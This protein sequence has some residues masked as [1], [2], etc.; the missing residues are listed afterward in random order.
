MKALK[1]FFTKY[2]AYIQG[3]LLPLGPFGV[4]LIAAID[5]SFFGVPMDPIVA[6]FVHADPRRAVIYVLL[7]AV[8][9]AVGSLVPYVIGYKGGEAFVV[10]K[11]GQERFN[12]VHRLSEK[13]GELA[14]IIP[15]MMPPGFPFKLFVFSAGVAEM[16]W[17]HFMLAVFT[18]RLL[19][20]AILAVLVIEFGPQVIQLMESLVARHGSLVLGT[21]VALLV[22]GILWY[23]LR[24][25]KSHSVIPT[26]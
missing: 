14:L 23:L 2:Q 20:F 22:A 7:A 3:L 26:E 9:S 18:G 8:G 17:A 21:F 13:Y 24:K 15:A 11:V 6:V 4:F 1:I 16:N 10:K 5:A 12:R 25:K 19:R